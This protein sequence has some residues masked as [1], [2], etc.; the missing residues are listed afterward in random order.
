M[1]NGT[2]TETVS[3]SPNYEN[4]AVQLDPVMQ[5]LSKIAQENNFELIILHH[6]Y[7]ALDA[8][9]QAYAMYNAEALEQFRQSC[10]TNNIRFLCTNDIFCQHATVH[11]ELPYGFSNTHPGSG[12]L[13]EVGHQLI[14]ELL[15]SE[16][17]AAKEG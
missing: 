17:F 11:M 12:H 16:L 5:K 13:N 2:S 9:N 6:N 14:A 10:E 8:E 4:Y 15:Y 7:I 1:N 3:E